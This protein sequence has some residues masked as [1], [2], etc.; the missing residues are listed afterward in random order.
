MKELKEQMTNFWEEQHKNEYKP[1]LSGSE[2]EQTI[3]WLKINDIIKPNLNILEVGVGLGYVTKKLFENKLNVSSV[4]ISEIG[5]E[6]VKPYC[7]KTYNINNISELPSNYFDI[8][9]CNLVVQ[10]ISTE[11]LIQ[12][13]KEFMRSLKKDGVFSIQ[14]VSSDNFDDNGINA[15]F[16]DSQAGRLCRTP[17]VMKTIFKKFGGK[18]EIVNESPLTSAWLTRSYVF[19]VTKIQ[20]TIY[21]KY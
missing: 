4:D 12:E 14:F 11:I 17:E 20:N 5:L 21:A 13:L 3:N 7:E 8:I 2:Y 6:R 9:I 15:S 16:D 10:H 19:H 18:C 1:C